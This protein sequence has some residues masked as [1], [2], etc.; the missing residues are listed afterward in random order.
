MRATYLTAVK[1]GITRLRDKGGASE[2]ALFDLLNGYVTAARTIRMRQAA[3]IQLDLPPGTIGLTSFKGAFVVYADQVMP[4]GPGYSVVVLKHPSNGAATLKEIHYSLPYLGFLYVVAEFSDGSTYHYWLEEGKP[5]AANTTYLPGALVSPT[6]PN[7]LAYSLVDTGGGHAAWEAYAA[8]TIGN[9]VVPSANNGFKYTVSSVS[10]ANARSGDTEP[11]WPATAG[12]T[13]NEDVPLENPLGNAGSGTAGGSVPQWTAAKQAAKGDLIRPVNLPSP[14]A[15]APINGNFTDGNTGWDLE[16][17]A[18]IVAGKLEL[19]GRISDGAAVN[20]ARFVV[21]DGGSLTANCLIEQGPA[22]AGATRGWVE[23]RWYD[24]DDV[25]ISYTQGNIVSSDA[26]ISTAVSPKPAG[27]SYAR[28]VIALWSVGDHD[29]VTGADNLTVSGAVNG[30]PAGLVYRAVQDVVAHTG[31]TEPAW[32]NILGK[33]V[34]DGGVTWEAM[35]IT[36]VTWTASPLYVSGGSEPA[37]PTNVGGTV[38]DGSVTWQAVSRRVEDPNC[39][40]SKVVLIGA[41]KVFAGNGDTVPYSATVAPKDWSSAND[42]GFLPTGLQNY[43]ANPVAAMGLYRGNLTV[44]NAEAFQLWQIDE[45]PASMSLLDALPVGSTQH[46][47]IAAVGNDLLFL[48]SQGVRSV[49]IAASSTNFQA[50]DVGMPIDPLVQAW[51]AQPSVVPRGL[52]FP[53]AGQYW[54]MFAKDG[55]TEVFVYTMT[56]IGQVGAWSRYVFPFEVHTWAIQGD[57][58]YLRSANRIYRMVDGAIGDELDPGVFTP[59]QGVIQ[60][61]WLDFGPAGVTKMLYGF[62][63]VGRGKVGIQ[64]GFDQTNGGAFTPAYQVDPD[65]L[66]GGPVPMSMAAPT[67]AVRL[68]YDGTEAWQWNAFG[69]YVQ[70]LRPM[71]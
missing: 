34:V 26:A 16:G 7:G 65:T 53:A 38:I 1:A 11:Q 37:W 28:G 25:M 5:W 10:G 70:D 39:P 18:H 69:L 54:L 48:A 47:A 30:L 50:G 56:Q 20:Q 58:L 64:V 6:A 59:F 19:P 13:V 24:K 71:A 62:E 42:A 2:D 15:T 32:P 36:R 17:G 51:L 60:W 41:S 44:F 61:P 29:H 45:D 52:Y 63:V 12:G 66:T 46:R 14:T 43:G 33:R 67:F 9:V 4:A 35:A 49:G 40:N 3:R 21:A 8:R 23:V 68:V 31:A 22:K 27:A 55:Q 57:A